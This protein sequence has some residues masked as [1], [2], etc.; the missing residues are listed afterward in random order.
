LIGTGIGLVLARTATPPQKLLAAALSFDKSHDVFTNDVGLSFIVDPAL[1]MSSG[2]GKD[3][4]P[5]IDAPVYIPANAADEWLSDDELVMALNYQGITRAYPL[6]ILVWHEIVNDFVGSTPVLITYC[7]LC[8]SGMAYDRTID[9]APIEF[10]TSGKLY[11]SNLVLYDRTT[12]TFWSQMNGLAIVG[13]RSGLQL[14]P[15]RLDTVTWGEWKIAHPESE[16][17]SRDT[18]FERNYGNDPYGSYYEDSHIWFP[19]QARDDR[20][21]PKSVVIGIEV[22]GSFVAY[23]E[24]DVASRGTIQDRVNG[25][26]I[27]ITQD[28]SGE[29]NVVNLSTQEL[30]SKERSFW[31]AWYAFHPDTRL[32][33]PS[34]WT[35]SPL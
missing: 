35:Y 4:I 1:L 21:H 17:L 3:G 33:L 7:P 25:I 6:Q 11:N 28:A 19:V 23:R 15:I 10:G 31:F 24:L 5:S 30:I 26:R 12:G 29:I 27:R 16:V 32:Y 14:A 18:G 2:A 13:E 22:N 8:G 9:G 34:D 20:I